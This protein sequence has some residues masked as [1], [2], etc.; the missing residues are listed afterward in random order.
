MTDIRVNTDFRENQRRINEEELRQDR[1]QRLQ[2]EAV[3]SGKQNAGEKRDLEVATGPAV[4]S[5]TR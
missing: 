5:L 4:L 1:L 2:E 3:R